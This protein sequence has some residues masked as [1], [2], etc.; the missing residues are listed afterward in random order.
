VHQLRDYGHISDDQSRY[1]YGLSRFGNVVLLGFSDFENDAVGMESFQE[2]RH[3]AGVYL[4][5]VFA[6]RLVLKSVDVELTTGQDLKKV[7]D[8]RC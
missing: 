6:Q 5:N 4:R 3:R 2:S 7:C 1:D 8:R